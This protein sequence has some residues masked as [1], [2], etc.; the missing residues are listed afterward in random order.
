MSFFY[1]ID[2]PFHENTMHVVIHCMERKYLKS[3]NLHESKEAAMFSKK[4]APLIHGA[5]AN[6]YRTQIYD[7]SVFDHLIEQYSAPPSSVIQLIDVMIKNKDQKGSGDQSAMKTLSHYRYLRNKF[8]N[9]QK[10]IKKEFLVHR[11]FRQ[12]DLEDFYLFLMRAEKVSRHTALNLSKELITVFNFAVKQGHIEPHTLK[13]IRQPIASSNPVYFNETELKDFAQFSFRY[14]GQSIVQ[15]WFLIMCATGL[16]HATMQ[17]LPKNALK[18]NLLHVS[19]KQTSL[20]IPVTEQTGRLIRSVKTKVGEYLFDRMTLNKVNLK[21]VKMRSQCGLKKQ[22]TAGSARLTF[23][24]TYALPAGVSID[25]VST[26]FGHSRASYTMGKLP[27]HDV[28]NINLM[29]ELQ[30]KIHK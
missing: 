27:Y 22:I 30:K 4:I 25:T 9:F 1:S 13:K 18:K 21:L 5:A 11:N 8:I 7:A 20:K 17:T 2:F 12:R 26:L 19:S 29:R 16:D 24:F 28:Q 6:M 23:A 15:K 3:T 10:G 14:A